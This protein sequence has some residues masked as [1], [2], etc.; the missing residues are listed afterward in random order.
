M[1]YKTHFIQSLVTFRAGFNCFWVLRCLAVPSACQAQYRSFDVI[2]S[3]RQVE[4]LVR[5]Q[6]RALDLT[7]RIL[8]CIH[9]SAQ[10]DVDTPAVARGH[11]DCL[12]VKQRKF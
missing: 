3:L 5:G 10:A 11:A 7:F 6:G 2:S 9:G 4:P 1:D 12:G 8:C